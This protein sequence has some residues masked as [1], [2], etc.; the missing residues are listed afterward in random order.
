MLKH[1]VPIRRDDHDFAQGERNALTQLIRR[2]DNGVPP[3]FLE[4]RIRRIGT[5]RKCR[6]RRIN[7]RA[8]QSRRGSEL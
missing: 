3:R 4:N 1:T 2:V 7:S 6:N 8:G 5:G